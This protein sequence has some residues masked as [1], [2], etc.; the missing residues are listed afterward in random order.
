MKIWEDIIGLIATLPALGIIAIVL[1]V[2]LIW[3]LPAIL[4]VYFDYRAKLH[5]RNAKAELEM[6]QLELDFDK[7]RVRKLGENKR[8]PKGNPNLKGKRK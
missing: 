7:D 2:T 3:R 6:R 4:K 1:A 5:S 8:G